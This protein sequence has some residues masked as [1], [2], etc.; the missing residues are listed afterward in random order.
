MGLFEKPA[1][2]DHIEWDPSDA[3]LNEIIV[4][5]HEKEEI[6]SNS[7]ITVRQNQIAILAEQGGKA[8]QAFGPGRHEIKT[9]ID[10]TKWFNKQVMKHVDGE[11]IYRC[12]VYFINKL[13]MTDLRWGTPDP[14]PFRV[15]VD[16]VPVFLHLRANGLFGAHI[17]N[18]NAI[19]LLTLVT[20]T[21]SIW[22]KQEIASILKGE[23][24][25]RVTTLLG[26]TIN[27]KGADI[28]NLASY[29][30]A[31]SDSIKEQ[32]L[33]DFENLGI[34]LD[35]FAFNSIDIPEK[36]MEDLKKAQS[37]DVESAAL[38]RKRAR[39][40]YTYQQE[41]G[42]DVMGTAAANEGMSGT[43]M[44]AGMGL[45]MGAG[46]GTAFGVG[47]SGIAQN[48][49]GQMNPMGQQMA[50]PQMAPQQASPAQQEATEK[51][52]KCGAVVAAGTKFCGNCGEKIGNFCPDCGAALPAGAKFCG[53][54]GKKLTSN[55]TNCGA[56][57]APGAKFCPECGT[58]Q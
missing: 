47:M 29:Y 7:F 58:K 14:I 40:G 43:F 27:N 50:Q 5:R 46:M 45:G 20:G 1:K 55:C 34:C 38:A 28:F 23:L 15:M 51:C 4:Y 32:M 39:E 11:N 42:F 53:N 37:M 19:K 31:L 22:T 48:T 30:N 6:S 33:P 41:R 54:C 12:T 56:E 57:L 8:L 49:M 17:D 18:E 3:E 2:L 25:K 9:E 13:R 44:G 52:P 16:G 26:D 36:D 24:I 35:L 10:T 21:K